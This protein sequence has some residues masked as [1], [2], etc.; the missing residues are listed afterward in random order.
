MIAD[1]DGQKMTDRIQLLHAYMALN[2]V[3]EAAE[4]IR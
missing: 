3:L 2:L 4:A 1:L